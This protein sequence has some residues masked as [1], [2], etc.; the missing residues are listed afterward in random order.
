[1]ARAKGNRTAERM[2]LLHPLLSWSKATWIFWANL[3]AGNPVQTFTTGPD[4]SA[5]LRGAVSSP[6]TSVCWVP[7][8]V[9]RAVLPKCKLLAFPVKTFLINKWIHHLLNP[10]QVWKQ[11]RSSSELRTDMDHPAPA[12]W[13]G[14]SAAFVW[15]P[16]WVT[17]QV[18][19][20]QTQWNII[21]NIK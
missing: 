9:S 2:A 7:P 10:K 6:A 12:H 15:I 13:P 5:S 11:P 8:A 20:S 3:C 18:D 4:L 19:A 21:F 17:A 16:V 14:A 1:M